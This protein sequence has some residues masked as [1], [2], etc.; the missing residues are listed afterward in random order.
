MSGVHHSADNATIRNA[1]LSHYWHRAHERRS[2]RGSRVVWKSGIRGAAVDCR[3]DCAVLCE[4]WLVKFIFPSHIIFIFNVGF[5]GLLQRPRE[6][7]KLHVTLINTRFRKN[8]DDFFDATNGDQQKPSSSAASNNPARL[9]F[10]SRDILRKYADYDFG[11]QPVSEVHISR[12][13]TT[14]CIGGFYDASAVAKVY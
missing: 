4:T 8:T 6:S 5:L 14:N 10:D 9:P 3:W 1:R 12:R 2:E 11:K 7:V 13:F